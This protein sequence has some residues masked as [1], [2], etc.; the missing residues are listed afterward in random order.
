[1]KVKKFTKPFIFWLPAGTCC[2]NLAIVFR[3]KFEI[4]QIRAI[5]S[6]PELTCMMKKEID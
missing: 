4:H 3:T 6:T 5:F 1:L 2:R